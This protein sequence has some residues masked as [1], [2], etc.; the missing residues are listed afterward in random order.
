MTY[1][2]TELTRRP[3]STDRTARCQFQVTGQPV[4]R[5]QAN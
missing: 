5:M 4:S 1:P 2:T 3:A